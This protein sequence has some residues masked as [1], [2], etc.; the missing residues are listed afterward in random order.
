MPDVC[1]AIREKALGA[2]SATVGATLTQLVAICRKTDK[3]SDADAFEARAREIAGKPA[4]E[5]KPVAEAK[6]ASEDADK[7]E[8]KDEAK[9]GEAM[10]PEAKSEDKPEAKPEDKSETKTES[11]SDEKPDNGS[12]DNKPAD[13]P[14][15]DK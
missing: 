1:L 4:A 8:T 12:A 3:A 11:K 13:K 14:E 9:D 10:K 7:G 2:N 6:P 5:T 15:M